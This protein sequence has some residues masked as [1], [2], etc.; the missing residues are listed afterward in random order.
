MNLKKTFI[1]LCLMS[2]I[3]HLFAQERIQI[4]YGPYLQNMKETEVT[5]VWVANRTSIGWVELAPDDGSHFYQEEREKFFDTRNGVKSESPVHSVRLTGLKPGTSYRY[6]ICVQEI[7]EH[8]GTEVTYGKIDGTDIW[9][10]DPYQFT[11]NN[12]GKQQTSF[13]ML[14]DIHGRTDDIPNLLDVAKYKETDFVI[15]NGDM[16]SHSSTEEQLFNSFMNKAI[17][18]FASEKPMYYARGNHETRGT[19]ASFFQQYFSV[20]E[21][22]LYFTMRQG[23]VFFIFLDTGEDK[24]DSDIAYCGITDYDRYRSEQ[25]IWLEKVVNSD[26][27]KQAPYKVVVGHMPPEPWKGVIWHGPQEVLQKFVPI[28]N[29]A[30]IDLMLCGHY[31]DN[32]PKYYYYESS[33]QVKFPVLVNESITV[34]RGNADSEKLSVEIKDSKGKSL[35]SKVIPSKK[36]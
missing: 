2:I 20:K 36:Q 19:F 7:L 1:T 31:H 26:E 23:P 8:K 35:F 30:G 4:K 17:E 13:V 15:F 32:L 25:A 14:N 9:S 10:Q 24:P 18:L 29:K 34:L 16:V 12:H 21:P 27:F 5:I 33:D 6:R 28:L 3:G 11:T 22:H